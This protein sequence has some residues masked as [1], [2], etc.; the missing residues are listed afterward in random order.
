MKQIKANPRLR[1]LVRRA[2][3]RSKQRLTPAARNMLLIPIQELLDLK[4]EVDWKIVD[5]SLTKLMVRAKPDQ[6]VEAP[7]DALS[8]RT[9]VAAYHSAF[10]NI[11]PFCG[12]VPRPKERR[13]ERRRKKRRRR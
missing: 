13:P 12:P 6:F 7:K 10:C 1:F 11:P 3:S 8:S 2:E 5:R 4:Y 9:I